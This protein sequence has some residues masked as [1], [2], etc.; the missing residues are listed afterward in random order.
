MCTG[1]AVSITGIIGF[2]GFIVP[3][4]VRLVLGP[5]HRYLMPTSILGGALL[6]SFADLFARTVMLP[7][8]LPIGL[9]TSA[10]G[11]PFFLIMLLKTYQQR[12]L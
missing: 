12:S 7:A 3:H 10:I 5:D 4:I 6:L 2:V 1:A 9:I 11:G 8:E